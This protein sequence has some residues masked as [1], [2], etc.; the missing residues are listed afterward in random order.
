MIHRSTNLEEYLRSNFFYDKT[1]KIIPEQEICTDCNSSLN[2]EKLSKKGI[3]ITSVAL[4]VEVYIKTCLNCNKNP[5]YYQGTRHGVINFENKFFICAELI[6]EYFCHYARNGTPFTSFINIKLQL[7]RD[8]NSNSNQNLPF[9]EVTKISPY[10]GHL[11]VAFCQ[12]IELFLYNKEKFACCRSPKI[13]QMDGVVLSIKSNRMPQFNFPW[14]NKVTTYRASNRNQRQLDQLCNEELL[15]IKGIVESQ[16]CSLYQFKKLTES[17]HIGI[18]VIVHCLEVV[19][20]HYKLFE[21]TEL[22]AKTLMKKV[23]PAA[24]LIP[25][26]CVTIMEK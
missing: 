24:S 12:S 9:A 20:T 19:D 23:A 5:I 13:L 7:T 4:Q 6:D 21:G 2:L 3:L 10:Y 26:T 16:K 11:H 22:F 15:I 25:C 8:A 14:L 17:D 18:N 1:L